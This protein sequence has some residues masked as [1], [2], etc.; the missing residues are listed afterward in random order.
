MKIKADADLSAFMAA[1]QDCLADVWFDTAAG[2]HLNLK[3]ALSQF[4]FLVAAADAAVLQEGC[5]HCSQ[6]S[7]LPLLLPYLEEAYDE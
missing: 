4:V 5:V 1:V 3:S 6:A 7:D 2:D